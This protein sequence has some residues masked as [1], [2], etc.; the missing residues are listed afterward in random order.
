MG[1]VLHQLHE[2]KFCPPYIILFDP[3]K[4]Y[5]LHAI[6]KLGALQLLLVCMLRRC[7][8]LS[9]TTAQ[10]LICILS[11]ADGSGWSFSEGA[12]T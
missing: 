11:G 6:V 1:S 4:S 12:T 5:D 8:A 10:H 7:C 9:A 3:T 2:L